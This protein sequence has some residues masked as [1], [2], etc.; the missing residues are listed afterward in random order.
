MK[1]YGECVM[2][3]IKPCYKCYQNYIQVCD[4]CGEDG[5]IKNYKNKS[6]CKSCFH[7][8][9]LNKNMLDNEITKEWD[10]YD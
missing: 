9:K 4:F 5:N 1:L 3:G 6:I 10:F 8:Q 2:C 7:R